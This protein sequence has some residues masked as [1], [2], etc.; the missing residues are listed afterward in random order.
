[1][2][3]EK[4]QPVLVESAWIPEKG[5]FPEWL[6]LLDFLDSIEKALDEQLVALFP[7]V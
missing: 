5:V 2:S 7:E 6:V 1:M 4:L 3:V